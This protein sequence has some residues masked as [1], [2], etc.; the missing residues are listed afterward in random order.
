MSS[1]VFH[2][3]PTV[4]TNAGPTGNGKPGGDFLISG[5]AA[6]ANKLLARFHTPFGNIDVKFFS[7]TPLTVQNFLSYANA[8]GSSSGY[9]Y[10]NT[11]IHRSVPSFV[12][13]GGGF[14]VVSPGTTF[15]NTNIQS[16]LQKPAVLNEPPSEKGT[17]G[18][19]RGTIAMAKVGNDPNSATNQW[20]FNLADNRANLDNQNGGFTVFGQVASAAGLAVMDKI[21]ALKTFN[22]GSSCPCDVRAWRL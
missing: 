2:R 8:T 9:S 15:D 13:Q 21:A 7:Q 5:K 10:D 17:P 18:N 14:R 3:R 19:I 1:I 20:F 22:L 6:A 16:I 11:F 12:I 4:T